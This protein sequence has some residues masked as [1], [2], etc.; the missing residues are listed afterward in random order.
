MVSGPVKQLIIAAVGLIV[1]GGLLPLLI[2]FAGLALLGRY[3]GASVGAVYHVVFAG[4]ARGS[5]ASWI[6]LL[7]PYV[8][9]QLFRGLILWWRTSARTV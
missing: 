5:S 1:G 4:L 3:E 9:F 7:G 2:Y 8:L 6:V